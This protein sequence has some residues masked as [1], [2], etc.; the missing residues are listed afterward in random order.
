MNNDNKKENAFGWIIAN[1]GI[2]MSL[3]YIE[4]ISDESTLGNPIIYINE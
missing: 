4:I 2:N 1:G 3:Y